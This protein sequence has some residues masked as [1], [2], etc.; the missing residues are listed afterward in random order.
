MIFGVKIC[1]TGALVC[2]RVLQIPGHKIPRA[3]DGN[4]LI[5]C[6]TQQVFVTTDN[7]LTFAGN[8]A[9]KEL[10]VVRIFTDGYITSLS[11]NKLSV[12][13]DQINDRRYV[14]QGKSGWENPC[15]APVFIKNL[16]G[17]HDLKILIFPCGE[18]L[19]W[20]SGEEYSRYEH[21]RIK[22]YLHFFF[23]GPLKR[24]LRYRTS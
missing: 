21:V 5:P 16:P 24:C 14:D 18:D 2:L 20:R 8:R 23:P 10:I 4:T 1:Q 17:K 11:I 9:F 6:K 7:Y 19:C 15:N 22:D 3:Q 13:R 12:D